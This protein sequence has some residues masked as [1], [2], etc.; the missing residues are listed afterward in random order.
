MIFSLDLF[1]NAIVSGILLGGFYCAV[2]VG[3]TPSS[4]ASVS[5]QP[6]RTMGPSDKAFRMA[7]IQ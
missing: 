2:A 6:I 5:F 4:R 3:I 7:A 1:S